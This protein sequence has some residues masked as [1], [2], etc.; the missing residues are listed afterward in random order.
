[1]ISTIIDLEWNVCA[2]FEPAFVNEAH[3]VDNE[4]LKMQ[5]GCNCTLYLTVG[6][7]PALPQSTI[8]ELGSNDGLYAADRRLWAPGKACCRLRRLSKTNDGSDLDHD[9]CYFLLNF[10]L[11]L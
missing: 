8:S 2:F 4:T 7:R 3:S 5:A 6:P 11:N 10:H 1:M 9:C